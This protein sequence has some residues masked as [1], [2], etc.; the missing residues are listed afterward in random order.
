MTTD[1]T[2]VALP[3]PTFVSHL[4]GK[5]I[6]GV[7]T[8]IPIVATFVVLRMVFNFIEGL[9]GP[10]TSHIPFLHFPGVGV[11]VMIILVYT[12]G[13]IAT[14]IGGRWIIHRL[15][16]VFLRIPVIKVIYNFAKQ[17]V[18]SLQIV[19]AGKSS[20]KPVIVQWPMKGIYAI[21][22]HTGTITDREGRIFD[23]V[24]VPTG[25]TPE[26]G[27]LCIYPQ[28]EV[29]ETNLTFEDALK[30]IVSRGVVSPKLVNASLSE[31]LASADPKP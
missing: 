17:I 4:R 8:L 11:A 18:D 12:A 13:L 28:S 24:L 14:T 27:V 22:F 20:F 31:I 25:P 16:E 3:K 10:I 15:E 29:L 5:L 6:A 1:E 9:V 21:A 2:E 23:N 30:M 7:F 19:T 26:S